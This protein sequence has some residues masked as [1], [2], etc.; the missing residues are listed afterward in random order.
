MSETR[1]SSAELT[2][3]ED[4]FGRGDVALAAKLAGELTTRYP[5]DVR[6][7]VAKA[8]LKAADGDVTSAIEELSAISQKHKDSGHARAY[9]GALLSA[10]GAHDKAIAEL[11]RAL[12]TSDGDVPAAHHSLGV[13]LLVNGRYKEAMDHLG[14]A[15]DAMPSSAPTFFYFGQGCEIAKDYKNAERA[16][17]QCVQI[18][19]RYPSAFASL[20]RVHALQGHLELAESTVKEGLK[21]NP[22]DPELLRFG[23]QVA[24]DQGDHAKAKKALLAIPERDRDVDDLHNLVMLALEAEDAGEAEKHGRA[25]VKRDP[26]DWRSHWLLGLALEGKQ[27]LPRKAVIDAYEAAIARGDPQGEAGTRLG[28][29]LL[30]GDG[31]D[32]D[33]AAEVLEDARK[34]N[35]EHAGLLLHLALARANQGEAEQ[36]KEL[37]AAVVKHANATEAEKEQADK[38]LA[39]IAS[40]A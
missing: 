16:Y 3:L 21:H 35:P 24:F 10:T 20:V 26:N 31:A 15:A 19:P 33:L 9:L 22:D 5:A 17:V 14:K 12:K 11:E 28:L 4:A 32:P 23:V 38:L 13:S 1:P 29:V 6:G 37:A 25:A 2:A 7:P 30:Q 36:A 8:R 27:P 40:T 39:A 18:E 34:R